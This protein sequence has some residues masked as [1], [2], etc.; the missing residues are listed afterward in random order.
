MIPSSS[1]SSESN[2]G[3]TLIPSTPPTDSREYREPPRDSRQSRFRELGPASGESKF[4][5]MWADAKRGLFR[6]SKVQS[7]QRTVDQLQ[8][9]AK[10][11]SFT[12]SCTR[13][14]RME[15]HRQAQSEIVTFANVVAV[16]SYFNRSGF[17]SGHAACH[18]MSQ[19]ITTSTTSNHTGHEDLMWNNT[20]S[21]PG[22]GIGASIIESVPLSPVIDS[23]RWMWGDAGSRAC[24]SRRLAEDNCFR[25][26]RV[27]SV[28]ETIEQ[29]ERYRLDNCARPVRMEISRQGQLEV[30]AFAN[31]DTA[32]TRLTSTITPFRYGTSD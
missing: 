21:L 32:L 28:R 25:W 16:I 5:W 17:V 14:V 7:A 12:K 6:W 1:R 10:A 3:S 2:V 31:V 26:T 13:P 30:V 22:S 24:L 15:I 27:Q 9:H 18:L 4:R 19:A 11:D 23:A 20:W 8:R 29:L